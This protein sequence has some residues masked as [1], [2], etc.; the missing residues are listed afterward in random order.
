MT[1]IIYT[2]SIFTAFVTVKLLSV[3]SGVLS[4]CYTCLDKDISINNDS[5]PSA[6]YVLRDKRLFNIAVSFC[7][8]CLFS[9]PLPL[10]PAVLPHKQLKTPLSLWI[11]QEVARGLLLSA[12]LLACP[13]HLVFFVL[14]STSRQKT[15]PRQIKPSLSQS[16]RLS[17]TCCY[18]ITCLVHKEERNH[19]DSC[20][21]DYSALFPPYSIQTLFFSLSH[22]ICST[23]ILHPIKW[24]TWLGQTERSVIL[25]HTKRN[26]RWDERD[27][28]ESQQTF[29]PFQNVQ[30]TE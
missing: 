9:A 2:G 30:E 26:E 23:Q 22:W 24:Q 12:V 25:S 29:T 5:S 7:C 21:R 18:I 6:C 15:Q 1:V 17:Q 8:L 28:K 13:W 27:H 4:Q 3:S 14:C 10:L 19:R 11:G 16:A 20:V